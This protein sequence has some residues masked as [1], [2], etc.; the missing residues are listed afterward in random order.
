[1]FTGAK[2]PFH[3]TLPL[4]RVLC[5]HKV[6]I[7]Y[8]LPVHISVLGVMANISDWCQRALAEW[9]MFPDLLEY[10]DWTEDL[11]IGA[12]VEDSS[13]LVKHKA[14]P[15]VGVQLGPLLPLVAVDEASEG[16]VTF[17]VDT[18]VPSQ[19]HRAYITHEK[20][21]EAK[22]PPP[23]FIVADNGFVVVAQSCGLGH[24]T[25]WPRQGWGEVN[26]AVHG[27]W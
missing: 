2:C 8:R 5:P 21:I 25:Y 12:H 20:A 3:I 4:H 13:K 6:K 16:V 11:R 9:L 17:G 24:L 7:T 14:P 26:I 15:L 27:A 23:W 22:V 19:R 10:L 1:M 18:G